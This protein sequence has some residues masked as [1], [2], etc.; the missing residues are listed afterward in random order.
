MIKVVT[1]GVFDLL[2]IGHLNL[3]E[4]CG[5]FGDYLIVAVHD[6][7]NRSKGIDFIT[8]NQNIEFN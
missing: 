1:F 4:K 3:L 7:V 2:N 8:I 6:D 5:D